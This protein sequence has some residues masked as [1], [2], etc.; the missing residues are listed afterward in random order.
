MK[1]LI[2]CI[3]V[4]TA[5][6]FLHGGVGK[7]AKV[8]HRDIK[9]ANILLNHEWKAKLGDFRLSLISPITHNTE[10]VIDY[11][12]GTKGYLDPLY[13]K[14]RF[15]TIESDV[16]S[17]GVVLFEI[18]CGKST[19]EIQKHKGHY[20]PEF[21]RNIFE[22]GKHDE[23]VFEQIRK[24][25]EPKSLATFQKITYQCLYHEREKR[26]TTR[27]VL[28]ELIKALEYQ[29]MTSTM[30]KFAHL[31]IQLEDVVK[32]TNN[33]N[34]DNII[35]HTGCSTTY[36]GRLL[37]SG[38]RLMK[39]VAQ[40]FDC[41]HVEAD[42][43]FFREI[44]V[45][46]DLK[47][48][49]LVSIVGF[50][51]EKDEK[52]IVTTYEANGSLGQYLNNLNLT[53]I[54]RLKIS[55]G[56][57]RALSYL[58]SY[59]GRDYAIIHCNINSDTILLDKNW[60]AKLSCFEASI[61]LPVY[62]KDQVSPC[63]QIGL[64][65]C[66]DPTIEK[67][68]GVSYKSDIY[69]FRVVLLEILCGRKAFFQNEANRFL[70]PLAKDHYE[71]GTLE[72][73]VHPD[74]WKQMSTQTL[75]KYTRVAYSCVNEEY[76]NR[77]NID[78]VVD[79]LVKALESELNING[80]NLEHLKIPLTD[81]I[82]ATSNFSE[83]YKIEPSWQ[84]DYSL[85]RAQLDH[86]D[87]ENP[88]Y[89]EGEI[90]GK[91]PKRKS[92]VVVKRYQSGHSFHT[93][94]VFFTQLETLTSI[95]HHNI[96]TILGFCVE[97]SEMILVTENVSN[98]YLGSYLKHGDLMCILNWEKRLK[99]CIDV[100]QALN[101][102]HSYMEDQKMIIN[103]DIFSINIGLDEKWGALITE[104]NPYEIQPPNQ[105]DEAFYHDIAPGPN[106]CRDPQYGKTGSFIRESD[107][108]C[109]GAVLLEILCGRLAYDPIYMK[110]S[111]EGLAYV[112]RREYSTGTLED[113]IDPL[114]KEETSENSFVLN[115]GPNKDS[116]H[117]FIKIAHQ[118]V[119]ETQDQNPTM[120]VVVEELEKALFLHV[121]T[122]SKVNDQSVTINGKE[123]IFADYI[124]RPSPGTNK[125]DNV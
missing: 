24:Q 44:S 77:P 76:S 91:H 2:I 86:F 125:S 57:A 33:F 25:I 67:M 36:E 62:N 85:Y 5:L 58:H 122:K 99:I 60:E 52:I 29:S 26:L 109:F 81:I 118:C 64:T 114:I 66:M 113:M 39:I 71:D 31:Q 78:D 108:Y 93:E 59:E 98:G 84:D 101:Y 120:K 46:Y 107:V 80:N 89:M 1:R 63:E 3:D 19:Y 50:C 100:A 11:A 45:L 14:S 92:T 88:S 94:E 27:K 38:S 15:L 112:A 102:L 103:Y 55:V 10:Y 13:E 23:V 105:E 37:Q 28:M 83:T 9:T 6:Y 90:K 20:L 43:K 54:Q 7:Q 82:L 49:N 104:F 115:R 47:H 22:E 21:I 56:V 74:L 73:I 110:E 18:L 79:T 8:I 16:Y 119:V 95:K 70:A 68:G 106:G 51:D 116:L 121:P 41:K 87:K 48:T 32:A 124:D 97:D 75:F 69:L 17:F 53:W 12:C 4:A 96:I 40:R 61:K 111:D 72:D 30:T 34:D 123:M 42:L 35:G 117:T 65:G